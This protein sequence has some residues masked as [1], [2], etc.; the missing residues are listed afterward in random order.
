MEVSKEDDDAADT[1][2]TTDMA[3]VQSTWDPWPTATQETSQPAQDAPSSPR[4]D[5]I[6][7]QD[8]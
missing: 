2:Y 7:A 5:Q 3:A 1:D 4:E 8:E 6:P